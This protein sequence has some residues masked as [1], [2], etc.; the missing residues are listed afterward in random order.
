MSDVPH[1]FRYHDGAGEVHGDPTALRRGMVAATG[2]RINALLRGY[3]A[4]RSGMSGE[5]LESA[6]A[7]QAAAAAVL[8]PAVRQTFKM[9]P[10]DPATG[11]GATD[12][13]CDRVLCEF[14]NYLS[15][16]KKKLVSCPS[17]APP[18]ARA[19]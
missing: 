10:F 3:Y 7:T 18:T 12:D 8:M 14:Q 2:G 16:V 15:A 17:T 19:S 5:A 1:T 11:R 9:A 4:V 6:L 13:D